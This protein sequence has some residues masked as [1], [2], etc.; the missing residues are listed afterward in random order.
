MTGLFDATNWL[1]YFE[2]R[3][4]TRRTLWFVRDVLDVDALRDNA[5]ALAV[6]AGFQDFKKCEPFLSAFPSAFLALADADLVET[7][8]DALSEFASSVSVL[9]PA[10]GVFRDYKNIREV[11]EAGGQEAVDRLLVGAVER[12]AAGLLDLAAVER[13]RDQPSI[14]TGIP[15]LDR[16]IG[17]LYAGEVSVHTGKR[18]SGKSTMAGQ[19]LIEALNQGFPV[20]AYSGELPSWRFKQW[21][22]LQAA[23]PDNVVERRDRYSDKI[24]YSV[25]TETQERIDAW[26][27][28]RFWLY[29]NR[30]ANDEDR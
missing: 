17:G 20:C 5:V 8:A 24:F 25:P 2:D 13:K 11:M 19:F 3:M 16:A 28:G 7:L 1:T 15:E 22:S 12:P 30:L 14:L 4:D 10:P 18:G 23:G 29:D 27:K 6:G 21:A 9:K 26:W